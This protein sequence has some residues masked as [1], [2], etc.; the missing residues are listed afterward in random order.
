MWGIIIV[1]SPR[2]AIDRKVNKYFSAILAP[3]INLRNGPW[4]KKTSFLGILEMGLVKRV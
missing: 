1:L 2:I 3:L 4:G